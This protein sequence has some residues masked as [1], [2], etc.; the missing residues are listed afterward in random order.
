MV[1]ITEIPVARAAEQM[2]ADA[3]PTAGRDPGRNWRP[4]IVASVA[5]AEAHELLTPVR[6]RDGRVGEI[7]GRTLPT[8]GQPATYDVLVDGAMVHPVLHGDVEPIGL[9]DEHRLAEARAR[10]A[11]AFGDLRGMAA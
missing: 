1:T 9:A 6:L 5:L 11:R 4:R 7:R 3:A 2:I 10:A 8:T